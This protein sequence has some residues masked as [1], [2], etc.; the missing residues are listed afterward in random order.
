MDSSL[1]KW[2]EDSGVRGY[3]FRGEPYLRA[4]YDGYAPPDLHLVGNRKSRVARLLGALMVLARLPVV[5]LQGDAALARYH[6]QHRWL[7]RAVIFIATL[8]VI[9]MIVVTAF[10]S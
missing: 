2:L 8:V 1:P 7:Y 6:A 3:G 9:S 4:D 10:W 5:A